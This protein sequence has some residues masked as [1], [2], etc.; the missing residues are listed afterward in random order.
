MDFSTRGQSVLVAAGSKGVGRACALALAAEGVNVTI[1]A[2]G[3]DALNVSMMALRATGAQAL[4]IQAD[5]TEPEQ[6][7]MVVERA[8]S[9]FG[10]LDILICS[11]N[12][13]GPPPRTFASASETQ[14]IEAFQL[15][16]LRVVS[17]SQTALPHLRQHGSGRIDHQP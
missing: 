11:C 15:R 6:L 16:L 8:V 12:A 17:L 14:W 4:A 10:R 7:R 3:L 2:C 9:T 1:C 5:V 13:A